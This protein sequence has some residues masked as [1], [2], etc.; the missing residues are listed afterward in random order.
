M[1][2]VSL[3]YTP[4]NAALFAA[5]AGNYSDVWMGLSTA[6]QG[7]P[8]DAW[9]WQWADGGGEVGPGV[10]PHSLQQILNGLQAQF[11]DWLYYYVNWGSRETSRDHSDGAFF[12][13]SMQGWSKQ[14]GGTK[15]WAVFV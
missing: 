8:D 15:L 13:A 11:P 9:R 3:C 14:G 1:G 6:I 5:T 2:R 10:S 7:G 12:H 4:E